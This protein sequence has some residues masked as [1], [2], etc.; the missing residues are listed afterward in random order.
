MYLS[1]VKLIGVRCVILS[2]P[3]LLDLSAQAADD[4]FGEGVLVELLDVL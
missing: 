1:H 3:Q 2:V 4:G